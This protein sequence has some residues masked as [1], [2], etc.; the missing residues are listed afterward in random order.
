L[1]F[2]VPAMLWALPLVSVPIIIHLLQRRRFRKVQFSAMDFLQRALRRTRRRVLLEDM[3]LLLLRTLAVLFF[4]LALARPSSK[5]LPLALGREAR[6]ELIVLDASLSM[7]LHN[8]DESTYERALGVASK[9][10][11]ALDPALEDRAAII[12]AGL[13]TDRIASGN[14][15]EVQA[16]L[17]ELERP[18]AA[19]GDLSGALIAATR[20]VADLA[21]VAGQVRVSILTDLQANLWN[22]DSGIVA[23]IEELIA[24]GC[25]IDLIDCG[26]QPRNNVA[27]MALEL[28]SARLVSGDSCEATVVLRN[29]GSLPRDVQATLFLDDTPVAARRFSLS[30]QEQ[31]DWN[32]PLSPVEVGAR[33]VEVRIEHDQLLADDS[34]A[35]IL[36]VDDGLQVVLVGQEASSSQATGVFDA[37][38]RYLQLGEQAPLR[39]HAVPVLQLGEAEL[40]EADLLVLADPGAIPS[41]T[42]RV[43]A[44]FVMQGGGLLIALGPQT[45][46]AELQALLNALTAAGVSVGD[47]VSNQDE[48]ARL[49][50]AAPQHP[51]L[52]FFT[53]Q[54][55]QPLLTEVPHYSYRPIA[56]APRAP[57]PAE[58]AL[59]FLGASESVDSGAALVSWDSGF[60]Q[61]AL[62]AAAP[63]GTWNRMEEVPG[64]T[65]PLLYDLLFSLAPQPGYPTSFE[66]GASLAVTVDFPPT[67][68][69][70][71]NPDGIRRTNV[72]K[73]T[74]L[75]EGRHHL[76][77]M[78]SVPEPGIWRLN[79][80]LLLPDGVE[81]PLHL[82]LAVVPPNKESDLRAASVEELTAFLPESVHLG[83]PEDRTS[84][85][86]ID[87]D[88]PRD[89]MRTLLFLVL[90]CLIAETLLAT[91]LDRRR[92]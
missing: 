37:V 92:T 91:M 11:S 53:D 39:P 81:A 84:S 34:R 69:E 57:A 64:G 74:I 7:G 26:L 83:H 70:L 1:I 43:I 24:L 72:A 33:A 13:T 32:V 66:I 8:D 80:H 20:T 9:R 48:P 54:R 30:A 62:L 90:A 16:A 87:T 63:H 71:L 36:T 25:S 23:P 31:R 73:A 88:L 50:I 38:Q 3:L 19:R 28:S 86:T 67:E 89:L 47:I 85:A 6:A 49:D 35:A 40:A 82:R 65:L 44:P 27:V 59:R 5:G 41:R 14:P 2:G 79:T 60:G 12:R 21:M 61:V 78:E 51:A 46:Q 42:V 18:D 22:R 55:W 58:I 56:V 45:G 77:L 76:E 10:L 4:I 29:F 17:R 68:T 15:E 52:R 75:S